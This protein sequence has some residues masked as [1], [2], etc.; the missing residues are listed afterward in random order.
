MFTTFNAIDV[1]DVIR[2]S[3]AVAAGTATTNCTGVDT[4]D[5]DGVI[6]IAAI[7]AIVSTGTVTIT[8]EES[9]DDSTYSALSGP[10]IAY[11]DT[12]DNKLAVIDVRGN[13]KRYVR[14]KIVTATANGTI[15][16][17]VAVRYGLK[18]TPNT[19]DATVLEIDKA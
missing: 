14:A 12:N 19:A 13:S 1:L 16:A 11:A 18:S 3:N 6:F 9:D 8:V 10:S 2:V 5:C 17:V 4:S 7:G 15:D